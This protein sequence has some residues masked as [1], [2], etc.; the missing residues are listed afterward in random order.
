MSTPGVLVLI[1]EPRHGHPDRPL[2]RVPADE[3]HILVTDLGI[4]RGDGVFETVGIAAGRPQALDAHLARL[5]RSATLL[6]L[7]PPDLGVFRAATLEV[8]DALAAAP[9]SWCKLVLTRGPEG[10]DRA[11]GWAYGEVS[12]DWPERTDG[13]A[14]VT[15]TR[16]YASDVTTSA[17]WLLQGAKS[18]SYALNRAALREAQRRG[19][20]DVVF[21]STDG[22]VLEGPTSTVV[23]RLGGELVTPPVEAGILPGTTQADAFELLAARGAATRTRPV[24]VAELADADALWLM[25]ST[26]L[27]APVRELDGRLVAVD[28]RLTADINDALAARTS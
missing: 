13:I 22:Y 23:L 7:P 8:A 25:S 27:A 5:A 20:D 3:P 12:R 28:V 4:T 19:A 26:R 1:D 15:L 2:R 18:L 17:P 9:S 16:G 21:T 14:V 10:A 11:T 24:R 6:E